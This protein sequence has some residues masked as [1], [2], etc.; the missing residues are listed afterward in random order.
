MGGDVPLTEDT[1]VLFAMKH[2]DNP[3]CISVEEFYQD[4][5][6][7]KYIKR[8]LNSYLATHKLNERLILNHLIVFFNLFEIPAGV[9]LLFFKLDKK[10]H[11]I[12]RTFLLYLNYVK[13]DDINIEEPVDLHVAQVLRNLK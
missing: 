6:R 10:F 11:S 5:R 13:E 3:N 8:H 7:I 12:L 2:Y 4:L 9:R 1:F